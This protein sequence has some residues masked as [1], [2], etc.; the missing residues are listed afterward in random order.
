MSSVAAACPACARAES[1]SRA[2]L[3]FAM[4]LGPLACGA[5]AAWVLVRLGAK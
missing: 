3:V 5:V 1:P 4:V 2:L